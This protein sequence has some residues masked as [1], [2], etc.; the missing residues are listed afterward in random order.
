LSIFIG[1]ILKKTVV[2]LVLIMITSWACLEGDPMHSL[3]G[4]QIKNGRIFR[5]TLYAVN[6]TSVIEG[7]VSTAL[8]TKLLL[9]T[10]KDFETR[11]LLQF[12]PI[13]DDSIQVDSLRLVLTA[14]NNQGDEL[15]SIQGTAHMVIN[16]WP[17]S[18]NEDESWN[19]QN[20]ISYDPQ[21]MSQFEVGED[22]S[23]YQVIEL[24]AEMM[25]VWQDTVGGNKNFGF[26][27][28]YQTASYIKQYSSVDALFSG[29]RPKLVYVW[30]NETQDSTH[31]D[32]I[33]VSQDA[34]LIDFT[35]I[36]DPEKLYVAS[37]YSVRSFFEFDFSQVPA[38]AAMA[39]MNFVVKRDDANSV[40][41]NQS[42]ENMYLRT[43][44]TPFVNLP[45]YSVDSTFTQNLYYNITVKESATN[46]LGIE[47]FAQGN[48]SQNFFQSIING[49]IEYGSFLLHY[50]Y[51]GEEVS[52]YTIHDNMNPNIEDR[53]MFIFEYFDVP[54][55]RM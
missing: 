15:G 13:P 52:V 3:E 5:D 31:H 45:S 6:H 50:K 9:G 17:E 39:N 41:N 33:Y 22:T 14:L 29:Q 35:G 49:D 25:R 4:D 47:P 55:T 37:G 2:V 28:D 1:E 54:E 44:T 24:P 42:L 8:S 20:N 19:W 26:L 18:V 48:G 38:S 11:S 16:S 21:Y 36:F 10:Y 27:L 43:V 23:S 32:T 51:E 40:K 53:P 7:K 46:M 34:S 12:G 30:Y